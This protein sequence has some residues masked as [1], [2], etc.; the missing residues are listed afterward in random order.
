[1]YLKL[2]RLLFYP[3]IFLIN[4]IIY[5]LK[6]IMGM[7]HSCLNVFFIIT[8]INYY[9]CYFHSVDTSKTSI[10]IYLFMLIICSGICK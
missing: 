5:F 3:I 6:I 9:C 4:Y 10:Y 2:Y 7:I 8:Y 1:M